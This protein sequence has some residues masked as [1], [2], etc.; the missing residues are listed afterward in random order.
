MKTTDEREQEIFRA[1]KAFTTDQVAG[2][3]AS[4][5]GVDYAYRRWRDSSDRFIEAE[6]LIELNNRMSDLRSWLVGYDWEDDQMWWERED[7]EY[8]EA[9]EGAS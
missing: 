2:L 8:A 6:R 1:A 9:N 3:L 7:A 4:M 5:E